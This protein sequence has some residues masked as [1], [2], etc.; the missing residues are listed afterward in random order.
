MIYA[1]RR[2]PSMS[3]RKLVWSLGVLFVLNSIVP[4]KA[5]SI[6]DTISRDVGKS[7]EKSVQDVGKSIEK[8]T[9]DVGKSDQKQIEQS[10]SNPCIANP[11]LP[12]CDSIGDQKAQ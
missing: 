11:R 6:F 8:A 2:R 12:Q 10:P 4:V 5:A 7:I 9:Q 3:S 1:R